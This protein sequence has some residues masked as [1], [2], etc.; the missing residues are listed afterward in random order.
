MADVRT[1]PLKKRLRYAA[2]TAA[3]YLLYGIF[4]LLPLD[5][6]SNAGGFIMRSLGPR[7]GIS[8][9]ARRNLAAAFPGKTEAERQEILSEC[10]DNL[11]RVIGEYPH[12]HRIAARV[13][14]AGA[15]HLGAA[16]GRGAI[17]FGAHSGNWEVGAVA[18]RRQ[19][20][21]LTLVYRRPNNPG[22]DGLLR[23]ARDSGGVGHVPKGRGAAREIM[24]VLQKQGAIAMLMDQKMNEGVAVPFFGRN[25]MTAPAI[26]HFALG[27]GCPV[28]PCRVE[29][30]GGA[31]FR[32]TIY[33]QIDTSS[34][35]DKAADVLRILTDV[36][37]TLESWI[38]ERPGQWLW[39]HRRWPE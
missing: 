10:W 17:F 13:E 14:L 6:A 11:G 19:G 18:A 7:M 36:N 34:T 22:V 28:Y 15:E 20:V 37:A 12:L 8:R 38:R 29:R 27:R 24:S 35:G 25:V 23:H 32:V 16:N 30:L 1:I 31:K 9:T 21:D 33:P 39:L 5:A 2:E 3:A 26:A 4:R